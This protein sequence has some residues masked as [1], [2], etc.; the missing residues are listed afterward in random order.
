MP[1]FRYK[2]SSCG[3]EWRDITSG[4]NS[5][6]HCPKCNALETNVKMPSG[7][8]TVV[9]EIK[10]KHRGKQIKKGIEKQLK[11]RMTEYSD[12]YELAEK[13]DKYGLNEAKKHG[14]LKKLK[15]V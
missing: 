4:A 8:A 3:Q 10:D 12:R 13:I 5:S 7:G 9:Y 2:C 14:W 6:S 15:K 1:V 11:A